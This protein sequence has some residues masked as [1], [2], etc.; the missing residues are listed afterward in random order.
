M[1]FHDDLYNLKDDG[2]GT[3]ERIVLFDENG[4]RRA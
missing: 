3:D 1:F 2:P 4:H